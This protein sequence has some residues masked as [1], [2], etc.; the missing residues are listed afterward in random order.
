FS[1]LLRLPR[2]RA[3]EHQTGD[4]IPGVNN[5]SVVRECGSKWKD[6]RRESNR[7]S[8]A[9]GHFLQL[10][11]REEAQPIT[12]GREEGLRGAVRSGYFARI[13]CAKVAQVKAWI[14]GTL[15][16]RVRYQAS[17]RRDR[18]RVRQLFTR[19]HRDGEPYRVSRRRQKRT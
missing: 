17:V 11:L 3:R 18:R 1:Q 7:R 10:A 19:F 15:L 13:K 16:G 9:H 5:A 2:T 4:L 12:I 8:T 14:A 6:G